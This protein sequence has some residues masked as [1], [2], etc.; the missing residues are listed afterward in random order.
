MGQHKTLTRKPPAR[1]SRY[2]QRPLVVSTHALFGAAEDLSS[3]T[4][5]MQY[6]FQKDMLEP[7]HT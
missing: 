4:C 5:S 6:A 2:D 1:A 7:T 3:A